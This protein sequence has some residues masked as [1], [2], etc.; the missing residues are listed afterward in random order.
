MKRKRPAFG[1]TELRAQV[2]VLRWFVL[3]L[4][5]QAPDRDAILLKASGLCGALDV[6]DGQLID[7]DRALMRRY[8]KEQLRHLNMR[9]PDTT[10]SGAVIHATLKH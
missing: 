5:D 7:R 10:P 4:C 1:I 9:S 3:A 2:A 8:L 6:D